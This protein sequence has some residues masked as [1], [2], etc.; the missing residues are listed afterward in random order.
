[1]GTWTEEKAVHLLNRAAFLASPEVVRASLELGREETVNRLIAGQSLT[2]RKE[3]LL[4]LE[5]VK[6]DGKNLAADKIGDQETYW[7]YRMAVTEAP[8][9]EKM[10]LFWHG[11]FATSYQKVGKV[12]L[13]TGQNEL[14]RKY[15][16]GSFRELVLA[17][18]KDPAM[19]YWLDSSS[20]RKGKPNENYARE[21]ME[22]FTLGIGNYTEDDVKSAARAFTGWSVNRDTGEV[23]YTANQHDAGSKTLFGRTGDFTGDQVVELLFEQPS[24]PSFLA[25]KLLLFFGTAEPPSSWIA[26]VAED[27]RRKETV[28]DVL[29]ELFLSEEFYLPEYRQ[30]LI[31]TPAEYVAGLM[32]G[33]DLPL[34]GGYASASRK[35]GQEL[36][37][38]PDVAGWRGGNS[39]FSTTSLLAR[40]QFAES[41]SQKVKAAVLMGPVFQTIGGSGG[42]PSS[43][44]YVEH[45]S[46]LAGAAPLGEATMKALS[47]YAED[48]FMYST[49]KTTGMRGLLQLIMASPEAQMK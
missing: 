36:Y 32:K 7:L 4:P 41:A 14:F 17:I 34:S 42:K 13:M 24:L 5:E 25:R 45:W 27:F 26:A 22:L 48:T 47:R 10:T 37:L 38:P 28:G 46:R 11:H 20:N 1:M 16:L 21:V 35:M 43:F 18:G 23:K 2:G 33:L 15:A 44:E 3:E 31:K 6:A 30:T 49:Q 8:L 12:P 9:I 29:R 39:W 19:M 40:Y